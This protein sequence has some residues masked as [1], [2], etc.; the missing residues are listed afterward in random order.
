MGR[1]AGFSANDAVRVATRT[2]WTLQRRRGSHL[3]FRKEDDP[4]T[5]SI[6]NHRSLQEGTLHSIIRTMKIDVDQFLTLVKG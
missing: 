5:L 2:G 4:R 3:I 1:L 6:P